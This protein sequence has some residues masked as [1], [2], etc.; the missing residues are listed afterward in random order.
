M[1][2]LGQGATDA[3]PNWIL[4]LNVYQKAYTKHCIGCRILDPMG[5]IQLDAQGKMYI[6]ITSGLIERLKTEYSLM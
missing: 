4:I 1:Y 6:W 2:G 5:T 3:P